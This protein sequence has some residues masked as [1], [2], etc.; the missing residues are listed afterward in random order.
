MPQRANHKH[1]KLFL[2]FSVLFRMQINHIGV[3]T[4]LLD[5]LIVRAA[6]NKPT[7]IKHINSVC[8]AGCGQAVGYKYHRFI[9]NQIQK[10]EGKQVQEA[11]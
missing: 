3:F 4:A 11:A 2:A 10:F 1:F 5:K 7:A 9:H 8:V 6:F